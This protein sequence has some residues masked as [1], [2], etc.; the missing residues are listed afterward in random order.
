LAISRSLVE[1][2]GGTIGF[3]DA[4][5]GGTRFHFTLPLAM[6]AAQQVAPQDEQGD[7][8]AVLLLV[9]DQEE[10]AREL[11]GI[12]RRPGYRCVVAG[13]AAAALSTL[14]A[15]PVEAVLVNMALRSSDPLAFIRELR[16]LGDFRHL[17]VIAVGA[18]LAGDQERTAGAAIGIGDW[19]RKPFDAGRVIDAVRSCLAHDTTTH[20]LH[21]EDDEDLRAM[22]AGLLAHDPIALHGAGTL[23]EARAALAARHHGLVI[24]DLMLPDGDGA[25]LL[26]ELA[27]ARP[28]TRVIIFTARDSELPESTVILRRLVKSQHGG[29][30]L[31]ALVHA[32]LRHWPRPVTP[33]STEQPGGSA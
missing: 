3:E 22:V 29:P 31:A 9:D 20:V 15:E 8:T 16:T 7:E 24:L 2:H 13:D 33:P 25:D 18:N 1:Q 21:V 14:G 32:Q 28:P 19:L 12:L 5:G 4:P 17:P 6:H 30:E 11:E 26:G 23:A 10:S 27:A